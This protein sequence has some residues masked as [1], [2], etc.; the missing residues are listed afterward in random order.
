LFASDIAPDAVR[1]A[2]RHAQNAGVMKMINFQT[3]HFMDLI[4]PP[5]R[6]VIVINPPYGERIVQQNL[7]DLYSQIG[8]KFKKSFAGFEAWIIS[9]NAEAVKHIGLRPS[10]KIPIYNGQLECRFNRYS[11]YQGSKK[12]YKSDIS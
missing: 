1:L 9:S 6:G 2:M 10:K 5:S 3:C 7:N 8:D 11:L 4:P 12:P